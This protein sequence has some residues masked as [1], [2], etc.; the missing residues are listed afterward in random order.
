MDAARRGDMLGRVAESLR[1]A[2]I[3]RPPEVA[4]TFEGRTLRAPEGESLAAALIADGIRRL[5]EGAHPDTPRAALCMMGVCQQCLAR[6]D[7]RLVQTCL[8]PVRA[9]M[10]VGAA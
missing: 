10:V 4:F 3:T 5:G 9:G 2:G 6:V 7:G 8:T 1:I